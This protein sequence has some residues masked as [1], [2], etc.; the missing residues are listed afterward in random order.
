MRNSV[1]SGKPALSQSQRP[2]GAPTISPRQNSLAAPAAAAAAVASARA[3]ANQSRR[4]AHNDDDDDAVSPVSLTGMLRTLAETSDLGRRQGGG[5]SAPTSTTN[6]ADSSNKR[7]TSV[8]ASADAGKRP[9]GAAAANSAADSRRVSTNK[10][11]GVAGGGGGG[12]FAAPTASSGNKQSSKHSIHQQQSVNNLSDI[13]RRN[14]ADDDDDFFNDDDGTFSADSSFQMKVLGG[15]VLQDRETQVERLKQTLAAVQT[16]RDA[17]EAESQSL[18]KENATLVNTVEECHRQVGELQQAVTGLN[19]DKQHLI[20]ERVS[21]KTKVRELEAAR[22]DD[23]RLMRERAARAGTTLDQVEQELRAARHEA[24]SAQMALA[25]ARSQFEMEKEN[26]ARTIMRLQTDV[27]RLSGETSARERLAEHEGQRLRDGL[28]AAN[29]RIQFLEDTVRQQ[30]TEIERAEEAAHAADLRESKARSE[31]AASVQIMVERDDLAAELKQIVRRHS[32]AHRQYKEERDQ[33]VMQVA[34]LQSEQQQD[35]ESLAERERLICDLRREIDDKDDRIRLLS[36]EMAEA[37]KT[38]AE[39]QRN[40][41]SLQLQHQKLAERLMSRH[42]ETSFGQALQQ[43]QQRSGLIAGVYVPLQ[44]INGDG[45]TSSVA[46]DHHHH[47][48][49]PQPSSVSLSLQTVCDNAVRRVHIAHGEAL[50]MTEENAELKHQLD[51]AIEERA[52]IEHLLQRK[53]QEATELLRQRADR[54]TELQ[55][56][57]AAEREAS[58]V[59]ENERLRLFEQVET[60][61]G[62]LSNANLD[63][64]TFRT[65]KVEHEDLKRTRVNLEGDKNKLLASVARLEEHNRTLVAQRDELNKRLL[66]YKESTTKSIKES[67]GHSE[68]MVKDAEHFFNSKLTLMEKQLGDRVVVW[69]DR[70]RLKERVADLESQLAASQTRLKAVSQRLTSEQSRREDLIRHASEQAMTS[71]IAADEEQLRIVD[72]A[73]QLATDELRQMHKAE[74]AALRRRVKE[75]LEAAVTQLQHKHS[76]EHKSAR[77]WMREAMQFFHEMDEVATTVAKGAKA[78]DIDAGSGILESIEQTISGTLKL[79]ATERENSRQPLDPALKEA[80]IARIDQQLKGDDELRAKAN[81]ITRTFFGESS[82][83]SMVDHQANN[84]SPSSGRGGGGGGGGGFGVSDDSI[85]VLRDPALSS[86]LY[87]SVSRIVSTY[88]Q[89]VR[90]G[91]S[92]APRVVDVV[93]SHR[94]T[95]ENMEQFARSHGYGAAASGKRGASRGGAGAAGAVAADNS[96]NDDTESG[97]AENPRAAAAEL[98]NKIFETVE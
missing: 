92:N 50:R 4:A 81:D 10:S 59:T 67:V 34:R 15:A 57:L 7:G 32:E 30:E 58:R 69:E 74:M 94:H 38:A 63:D 24:A 28:G 3:A 22:E 79:L 53:E 42:T 47:Q 43:Q 91:L 87:R 1:N 21:L 70:R 73:K 18:S 96:E 27:E 82:L 80:L 5:N 49:Q 66:H 77:A 90:N 6:H 8:A 86:A 51:I 56:R 98:V 83:R 29:E 35:A 97:T 72:E 40:M 45:S 11:P 85:A 41:S 19:R 71:R 75:K 52:A 20:G 68:R 60:L 44:Q 33:F 78:V 2:S 55:E 12:G 39:F 61:S 37:T 62:K 95:F 16:Q 48:H 36:L 84:V 25:E 46:S 93:D 65:I 9:G 54:V 26:I 64:D 13:A 23:D 14:A 31:S 88:T 89:T 76:V 17:Y